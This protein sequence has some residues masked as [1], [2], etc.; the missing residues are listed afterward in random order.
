VLAKSFRNINALKV[1]PDCSKIYGVY[2]WDGE[3]L[4]F[5]NYIDNSTAMPIDKL[6]LEVET[7][8]KQSLALAVYDC[9]EDYNPDMRN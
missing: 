7:Q 9:Y 2:S 5:Q 6:M 8:I 1:E 3:C 4:L